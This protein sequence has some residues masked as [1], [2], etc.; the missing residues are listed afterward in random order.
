MSELEKEISFP[1]GGM[2]AS[3]PPTDNGGA[4]RHINL[5]T[6]YKVP[7]E[8][9]NP[10]LPIAAGQTA[11]L[12]RIADALETGVLDNRAHH[13]RVESDFEDTVEQV[14]VL[15]YLFAAS[16]IV[17]GLLLFVASFR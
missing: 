10:I 5:P 16:L 12:C 3:S 13:A 11:A 8:P 7:E 9:A 15:V 6:R 4:Y 17:Q 14:R 1:D 2:V